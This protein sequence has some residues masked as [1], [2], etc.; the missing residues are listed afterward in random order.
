MSKTDAEFWK[1]AHDED[2]TELREKTEHLQALI[3]RALPY[4]LVYDPGRLTD[5]KEQRSLRDALIAEMEGAVQPE[6][7]KT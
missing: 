2:V 6:E 7:G 5:A 4:V 3:D 1:Q